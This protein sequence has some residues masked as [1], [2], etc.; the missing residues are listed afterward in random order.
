MTL[1]PR[2][3]LGAAPALLVVAG[4]FLLSRACQRDAERPASEAG[5]FRAETVLL[6]SPKDEERLHRVALKQEAVDDLLDGRITLEEAASR[7]ET[8][9][10]LTLDLAVHQVL[11]FARVGANHNRDRYGEALARLEAES[12]SFL[13]E[14]HIHQ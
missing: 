2:A 6:P 11:V 10:D 9:S 1:S 5:S 13:A 8:V 4:S 12:T 14:S 7:F 3:L